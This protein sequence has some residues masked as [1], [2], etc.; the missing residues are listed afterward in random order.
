M[1]R[2]RFFTALL[3]VVGLVAILGGCAKNASGDDAHA[4]PVMNYHR[5][6]DRLLTGGH[7]LEDGPAVLASEGVKVVIDLRDNSPDGEKQR[8][9]EYGIEW[10]N[11]P[12]VWSDPKAEDFD[13][14]RKVMASHAGE[15][16]MVQCAANYRASAMTYLYRVLEDD[17]PEPEA[18]KGITAIWDPD[19]YETWREFIDEMIAANR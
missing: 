1:T 12:V 9:A 11:V 16:V 4:G 8:Y 5:I 3:T 2:N 19:E 6:D 13:K 18:R 15:H 7:L 14:F 10:T 17:V